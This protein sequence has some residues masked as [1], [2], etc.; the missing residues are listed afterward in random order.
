MEESKLGN[1]NNVVKLIYC[2]VLFEQLAA[3][4]QNGNAIKYIHS[5]KHLRFGV[6]NKY[7]QIRKKTETFLNRGCICITCD[8]TTKSVDI[9]ISVTTMILDKNT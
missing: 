7:V 8:M 6:W 2:S 1:N 3:V 4:K 5:P 9:C